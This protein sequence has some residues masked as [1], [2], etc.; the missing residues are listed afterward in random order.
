MAIN[1]TAPDLTVELQKI[2]DSEINVLS[3]ALP[4]RGAGNKLASAIVVMMVLPISL[5]FLAAASIRIVLW[6]GR[7][8]QQQVRSASGNC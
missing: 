2:Y 4:L 1:N 5:V 3:F 7:A 6:A 8:G